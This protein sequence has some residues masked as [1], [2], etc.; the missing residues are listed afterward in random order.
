MF[1]NLLGKA[2]EQGKNALQGIRRQVEQTGKSHAQEMREKLKREAN[3]ANLT[4][5]LYKR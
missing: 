1:S 4:K 5:R 2:K 3:H